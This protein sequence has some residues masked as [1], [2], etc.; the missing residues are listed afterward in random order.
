MLLEILCT[1]DNFLAD[2]TKTAI[3]FV[4]FRIL[5]GSVK[6]FLSILSAFFEKYVTQERAQK[7]RNT[8]R[9]CSIATCASAQE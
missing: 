2:A 7:F 3:Y 5:A 9:I 1:T 6:Y 8:S 4:T